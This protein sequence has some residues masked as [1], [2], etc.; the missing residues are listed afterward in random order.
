MSDAHALLGLAAGASA[1][2]IKKA[3]RRLAMRWHPDR[4]PDPAAVEHFKALRAAYEMLT[5]EDSPGST[6]ATEA[7][8]LD[9]E[10]TIELELAFRGGSHLMGLAQQGACRLCEGS[11]QEVLRHTR[12]CGRCHGSG[13]L[14]AASG[15]CPCPDCDGRGYLNRQACSGCAGSGHATHVRDFEVELPAGI[16]DGEVLLI[17]ARA[18][19][20]GSVRDLRLRL[21][22]VPHPLF[23]LK[24]R[25]LHLN[26]PTSALLML[27][28]GT[29][30]VPTPDR[31]VKLALEAGPPT[32]RELR[33]R[34]AG[35]PARGGEAAGDLVIHLQPVFPCAPD[36]AMHELLAR[37]EALCTADR[38]RQQPDVALWEQRWLQDAAGAQDPPP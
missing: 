5:A 24:G 12:L 19:A 22:H 1:A 27:S 8:V 6:D 20:D 30:E 37:L 10:L 14:R 2:D 34:G 31:R 17:R 18:T 21:R 3:F 23:R 9:C 13:R 26:R 36:T 33:V 35:L 4:N 11:G 25:D 7:D 15:L 16:E 32:E 29:L 28:G 38:S